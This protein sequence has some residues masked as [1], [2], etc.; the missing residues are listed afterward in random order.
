MLRVAKTIVL[1]GCDVGNTLEHASVMAAR[2]VTSTSTTYHAAG[3]SNMTNCTNKTGMPGISMHYLPR[4][5][6]SWEK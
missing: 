2:E 1:Q 5:E 6:S 4:D 3:N